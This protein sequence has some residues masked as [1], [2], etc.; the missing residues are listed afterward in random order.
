MCDC[1]EVRSQDVVG[2]LDWLPQACYIR[3]TDP[4]ERVYE[5][6]FRARDG[7]TQK[8]RFN[9]DFARERGQSGAALLA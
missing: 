6:S 9:T 4:L 3:H 1:C 2:V 5:L 7:R 8:A